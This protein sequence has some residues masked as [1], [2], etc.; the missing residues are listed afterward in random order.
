MGPVTLTWRQGAQAP[1]VTGTLGWGTA[2]V[3]GDTAYFL[4][5][6]LHSYTLPEDKWTK[7]AVGQFDYSALAVIDELVTTIGGGHDMGWVDNQNVLLSLIEGTWKE[8]FPSMTTKRMCPAVV[9]TPTHLVVAGG[10]NGLN[11]VEIMNIEDLQ[12]FIA[13]NLPIPTDHPR[14]TLCDGR[15]Y[16][17]EPDYSSVIS[18]SVK[19]LLKSCKPTF[20]KSSDCVCVWTSLA[21]CPA[22]DSSLA[23]VRGH[24]LA[25][26]G[27]CGGQLTGDIYC[28]DVAMDSW[29]AV[30]EM[31]TPRCDVLTAVLPSNEL[32]VAGGAM[33]SETT[34]C[35]NEIGTCSHTSTR[36]N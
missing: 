20:Y 26:G 28:Y 32:V 6:S 3:H 33:G 15:L 11:T 29:S 17:L 19:D 27:K 18:C 36:T 5:G 2:V 31:P 25:V 30:G 14:M 7:L 34:N 8:V 24:L 10:S 21:N 23:T 13:S 16:L 1:T 35:I 12:W 22:R 9:T 4:S